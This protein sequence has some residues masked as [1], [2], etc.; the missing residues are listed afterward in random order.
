MVETPSASIAGPQV[1]GRVCGP[2]T[3]AR[4]KVATRKIAEIAGTMG[5]N[6]EILKTEI[7]K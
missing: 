1:H 6:S 7:L 5:I 2:I 4:I 3:T